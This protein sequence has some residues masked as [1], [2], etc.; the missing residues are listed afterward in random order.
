MLRFDKRCA[1]AVFGKMNAL[2]LFPGLIC[3]FGLSL[4]LLSPYFAGGVSKGAD[5]VFA[6][7]CRIWPDLKHAVHAVFGMPRLTLLLR[8]IGGMFVL[9]GFALFLFIYVL[10][11]R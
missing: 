1:E 2:Y 5:Y 10:Q 8:M 3:V 6:F 11:S 4:L 9:T 7:P